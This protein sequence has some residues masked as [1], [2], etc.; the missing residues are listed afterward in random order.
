MQSVQGSSNISST[1]SKKDY[2]QAGNLV[3]EEVRSRLEGGSIRSHLGVQGLLALLDDKIRRFSVDGDVDELLGLVVDSLVV[4]TQAT[5]WLGLLEDSDEMSLALKK[6]V[7]KME[8]NI[9]TTL[10]EASLC[11]VPELELN[12][13]P[14]CNRTKMQTGVKTLALPDPVCEECEE[15]LP[16]GTMDVEGYLKWIQNGVIDEQ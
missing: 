2:L 5:K 14:R 1:C 4:F 13:C 8:A 9:E 16:G 7:Q 15:Q 10:P 3:L 11:G 12:P 6:P